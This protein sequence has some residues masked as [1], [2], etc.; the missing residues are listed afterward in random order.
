[1]YTY[2]SGFYSRLHLESGTDR[3]FWPHFAGVDENFNA[4]AM[5]WR[6]INYNHV[7]V[8]VCG[9]LR[10]FG[11]KQKGLYYGTIVLLYVDGKTPDGFKFYHEL[12]CR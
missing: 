1:V 2:I 12:N 9:W 11:E 10:V 8:H 5:I 3:H 4:F 7:H 6:I